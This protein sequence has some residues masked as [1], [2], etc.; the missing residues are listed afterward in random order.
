MTFL[1]RQGETTGGDEK[2]EPVR[3]TQLEF[4]R[5]WSLHVLPKG[6]TR[7]RRIGGWSPSLRG[8][9]LEGVAIGLE[10]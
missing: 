8:E 2:Q 4:T 7:T 3:L 5:R 1:A 10:A 6:Y 9:Y